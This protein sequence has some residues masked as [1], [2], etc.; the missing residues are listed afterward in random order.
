LPTVQPIEEPEE[1]GPLCITALEILDELESGLK[2]IESG[3]VQEGTADLRMEIPLLVDELREKAAL[4]RSWGQYWK[5][6]TFPR[7]KG[8]VNEESEQ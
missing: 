2:K 6:R 3:R 4:L 8:T 1:P 7:F 5:E